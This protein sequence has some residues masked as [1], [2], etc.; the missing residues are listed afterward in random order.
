VSRP[1]GLRWVKKT[2]PRS[3]SRSPKDARRPS[4]AALVMVTAG[5]RG[6]HRGITRG[7]RFPRGYSAPNRKVLFRGAYKRA[8]QRTGPKGAVV[9]VRA[10]KFE[11]CRFLDGYS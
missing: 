11:N 6:T 1:R 4:R 10:G 5:A 7:R 9:T 2:Q 8:R 3:E